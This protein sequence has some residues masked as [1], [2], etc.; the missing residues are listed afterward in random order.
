MIRNPNATRPWQ[1]VL[2]PLSGYLILGQKLLQ[3]APGVKNE[4]FNFG[5][6]AK[7]TQSVS[8]LIT[9][10]A[11]YWPGAEWKFEHEVN[12]GKSESTLL[13]L[14]CDKA[15]QILEWRSAIDFSDTIRMTGEWY[16]DFYDPKTSPISETTSKQITEYSELAIQSNLVWTQ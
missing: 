13:K 15:L 5:P 11:Q 16:Q 3:G 1:H 4:S 9:D 2:E 12:S 14:N 10:M 7:V 6:S 8:D